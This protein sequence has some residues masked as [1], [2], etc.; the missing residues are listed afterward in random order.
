MK[1]GHQRNISRV[2]GGGTPE[3]DTMKFGTL[4]DVPDVMNHANYHV[5]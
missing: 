5:D 1:K 4:V 3:G 2:R